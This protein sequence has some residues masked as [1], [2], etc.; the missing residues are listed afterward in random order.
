MQEVIIYI[1]VLALLLEVFA[2]ITYILENKSKLK[3]K[4]NSLKQYIN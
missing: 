3:K 2:I 4:I 1:I